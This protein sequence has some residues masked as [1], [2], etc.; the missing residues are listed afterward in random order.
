LFVVV[1]FFFT[2]IIL[3]N[4]GRKYMMYSYKGRVEV[5]S[6]TKKVVTEG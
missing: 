5:G 2:L 6:I 4:R 1:V 3:Q